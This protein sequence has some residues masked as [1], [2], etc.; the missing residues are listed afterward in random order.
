M[1]FRR[2][3]LLTA[4]LLLA[5]GALA[6]TDQTKLTPFSDARLPF[7]ISAPTTWYGID[8]GDGAV[9]LSMVS[10]KTKPATMIRLLFAEKDSGEKVN[11]TTEADNYETDLKA[12]NLTVK[13]LSSK[14]ATY[15]GVKGLEREYQLTGG[16]TDVRLRVWFGDN[17]K[18]L[19]SFQ[20]TDTAPRYAAASGLFS[21]MLAT[22]K[23]R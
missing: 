9:G 5:S 20:L 13:R 17:A 11:L 19:F 14:D 18:N 21:K 8:L 15:G 6:Q 10:A 1:T 16:N 3:I 7:S 12:S 22:V 4:P 23:F 2:S